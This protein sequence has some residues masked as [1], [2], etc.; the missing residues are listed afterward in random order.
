MSESVSWY[1]FQTSCFDRLEL[2]PIIGV[3]LPA[4]PNSNPE[5]L[6]GTPLLR[7]VAAFGELLH[8][9]YNVFTALLHRT[10]FA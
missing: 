6:D 1:S 7:F 3:Q 5:T 4:F 8:T 9:F 10:A 2:G